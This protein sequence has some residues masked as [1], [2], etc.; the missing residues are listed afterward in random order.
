MTNWLAC[1]RIAATFIDTAI[2]YRRNLQNLSAI[3]WRGALLKS[4]RA[5]SVLVLDPR[6]NH[7]CRP[8][9]GAGGTLRHLLKS[10][11]D[12]HIAENVS[13]GA[14]REGRRAVFTLSRQVGS[15]LSAKV[16]SGATP[17]AIIWSRSSIL[18][19]FLLGLDRDSSLGWA[20]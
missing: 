6:R 15:Y 17:C 19:P 5:W 14:P 18:N 16:H 20:I 9:G 11:H 3:S 2:C 1:G 12:K 7:H 4:N 8:A 10:V 13:I